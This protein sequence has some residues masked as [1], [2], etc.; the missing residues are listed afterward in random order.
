M[1]NI[2]YPIVIGA[3]ILIAIVGIVFLFM[4]LLWL[5]V[6]DEGPLWARIPVWTIFLL[7]GSYLI[8]RMYIVNHALIH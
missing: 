3:G 1:F 7:G 6:T 2:L 5:L 4:L 8:G